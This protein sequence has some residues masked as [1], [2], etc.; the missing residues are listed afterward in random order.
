MG[1]FQL[2]D[3]S[4]KFIDDL[5]LYL[6]S[7]GKNNQEIKEITEELEVHLYEAEQNGKSID[8]IV[9]ASPKEYMT[10]I[11]N[12]MKTDYRAW[13]KYVPLIVIG[14]MSYSILGD[15]LKGTLQYSILEII[16]T[17]LFSILFLGGVFGAFRYIARNQVSRIKQIFIMVLPIIISMS[18]FIALLIVDSIYKT[19]IIDFGFFGSIFIGIL[20]L[21]F[22]ILFSFWGKTAILP[23]TLLALHLPAFLLS[24]TP[25]NE[26]TQVIAGMVITYVLIGLYVV[27][28]FKKE[29]KR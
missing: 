29:K 15:L 17:I 1:E 28:T 7:S 10:S 2:S 24:Y 11:S 25:L 20:F 22:V 14:G 3:K 13:A 6:F 26:L 9:G 4:T 19:H 21:C 27:Y 12:Q 8:Q 5:K 23:V 18:F 16:G